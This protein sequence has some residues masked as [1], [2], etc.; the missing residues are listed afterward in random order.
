MNTQ[1]G[2]TFTKPGVFS[3]DIDLVF[4]AF[5]KKEFNETFSE[6][7][8]GVSLDFNYFHSKTT[9]V[10]AGLLAKYGEFNDA[11]GE[12]E[13][14]YAGFKTDL[15][16][17]GRDSKLE[18]TKGL[19]AEFKALPFFET[20][21]DVLAGRFQAEARTYFSP[22]DN[23]RTVLAARVKAGSLVGSSISETPPDL[24]FTTGGGGSVR[25]YGFN[26]IGIRNN[27]GEITGG[28]SLLEGSIEIRQR[29]G[30]SFG[31]VAF[32]DAGTIGENSYDAFSGDLKIGAGVGL[33]YYTGLG[34]IRLDIAVPL[35]PDDD[36][37][38]F[39]IYAGIGQAF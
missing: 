21:F 11:F 36:D 39:G 15:L 20:N 8:A 16:F 10:S 30:E 38:S 23:G 35:N 18:P 1:L 12:R 25:G 22:H 3:P 6:T 24:L 26:N 17:D 32:L 29:F 14:F 34:A 33:R 31:A 9:T 19:Y 28:R 2:A 5:A 7:S 4:D 27:L 37:P 13:F